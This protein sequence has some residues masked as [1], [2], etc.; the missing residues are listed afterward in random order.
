MVDDCFGRVSIFIIL[1]L[2]LIV[3]NLRR[4]GTVLFLMSSVFQIENFDLFW[5]KFN[6]YCTLRIIFKLLAI[7]LFTYLYTPLRTNRITE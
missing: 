6:P 2:E 3:G 1:L 7:L 4:F 5:K